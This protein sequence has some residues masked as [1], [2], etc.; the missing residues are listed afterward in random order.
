MAIASDGFALSAGPYREVRRRTVPPSRAYGS[1]A[2][3]TMS[4]DPSIRWVKRW[5]SAMSTLVELVKY[6]HAR[7]RREIGRRL[8]KAG[9]A[10]VELGIA[11]S[12]SDFIRTDAGEVWMRTPEGDE[13]CLC[14]TS[15]Y[16]KPW[17]KM[18]Y[19]RL[20]K[21]REWWTGELCRR[22]ESALFVEIIELQDYLSIGAIQRALWERHERYFDPAVITEAVY[23]VNGWF[24][25]TK[26]DLVHRGSL[27]ALEAHLIGLSEWEADPMWS[28]A[29]IPTPDEI[30]ERSAAIRKEWPEERQGLADDVETGLFGWRD[31]D[32]VD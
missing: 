15:L 10:L 29:E 9:R 7:A 6:D 4:R 22:G 28:L 17:R 2:S 30:A 14:L 1:E 19:Y 31:L 24:H 32:S 16:G 13:F 21:V 8:I 12:I 27:D 5:D 20:I 25:L 23:R 26:P 18:V 11:R 3:R